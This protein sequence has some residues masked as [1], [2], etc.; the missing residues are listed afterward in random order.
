MKLERTFIVMQPE[1]V[2]KERVGS[3]LSAAGYREL[4]TSPMK[5][6]RGSLIGTLTALSPNKWQADALVETEP[7]G[8]N[9]TNVRLKLDVNTTGHIILPKES[10]YWQSEMNTF[11]QDITSGE[12]KV[13]S[14]N[15]SAVAVKS[16]V[17]KGIVSFVLAA[18]LVSVPAA[19]LLALLLDT[20]AVKFGVLISFAAGTIASRKYWKQLI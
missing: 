4:A 10:D 3:F 8:E 12:I 20:R 19:V 13:E 5:Y 18:L 1:T 7:A 6:K 2:V 14:L 15:R 16:L 9:Q 11:E 17:I